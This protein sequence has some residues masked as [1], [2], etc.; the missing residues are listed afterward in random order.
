MVSPA[1]RNAWDWG[2]FVSGFVPMLVFGAAVGNALQGFPYHF[3]WNMASVYTGSFISLFNPFAILAGLLSVSMSI[4]MGAAML[5]N[6][7]EGPLFERSRKLLALFGPLA[8]VLFTAGGIWVANLHGYTLSGANPG[9]D[10]NPL[11]TRVAVG[12]SSGAWLA[13]FETAP[14]LWLL[15]LVTYL[16]VIMGTLAGRAGKSHFAWWMG[17]LAWIGILGTVGAAM[18]PFMMPSSTSPAQSLTVWNASSSEHTLV[19]MTVWTVVF[20]PAILAYTSWAFWVMRGKVK[21]EQVESDDHA[22]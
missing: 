11:D 17:A 3:E 18:F 12:V 21:T 5:M 13:N 16:S 19:W 15:P 7:S 8:L 14:V 2:L 10:S 9:A 1:W 22:Y 4:Y 6:R 20:V